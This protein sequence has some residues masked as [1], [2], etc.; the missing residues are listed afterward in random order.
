V[1]DLPL[2]SETDDAPAEPESAQPLTL[3]VALSGRL[4]KAN[5]VDHYSFTAR[6]GVL[7]VFEVLS[8][9][10]GSN[11]DP[12]L[13]VIDLKGKTLIE[14]DDTYGKDPRIEWTAPA[15]GTFA[16]EV[17]DLH[18]RG[19]DGFGYVLQG[20]E[21][22]PDFLLSCDPDKLNV[23]PGARTSLFA[24][25]VRQAGFKGAVTV[26]CDGLPPG[27]SATPLTIPETM[28]QGEIVISAA[29]DAPRGASFVTITGVAETPDGPITRTATPMQEIYLPG[30]GRGLYEVETLVAAVTE[31]SDITV[32]AEPESITLAPGKTATIN[33]TIKRLDGFEGPVNLAVDLA[34][35]GRSFASPLPP[36]VSLKAAGSKTLIG[37][38]ATTGTIIL[39][40]KPDAPP[41]DNVPIA[42]MGHVSINFVV[43]TA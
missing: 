29:S 25:V 16:V 36:G 40:A 26:S 12:V 7:H 11:A 2:A 5:D 41:C 24:K 10:V 27:M 33:V 35:L 15:D 6:K 3:P 22:Q 30:G 39:E 20:S 13:R 42:V 14:A 4:N 32:E 21:A 1:T 18:S 28:T 31:P 9:R 37:P 19:G 23:G 8:R 34:H 43:K 17:R 38:K